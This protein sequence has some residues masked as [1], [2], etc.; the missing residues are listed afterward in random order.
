[1]KILYLTGIT[2]QP[3]SKGQSKI[4]RANGK[5]SEKENDTMP[6]SWFI[7]NGLRPPPDAEDDEIERDDYG[8]VLLDPEDVDEVGIP[9]SL[10]LKYY[11]G[12]EGCT[13][14]TSIVY[15]TFAY[16]FSVFEDIE[17]INDYVNYLSSPWHVRKWAEIKIDW[18]N[19][20]RKIGLTK[21]KNNNINN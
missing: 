18:L 17:E 1:M 9:I 16:Q 8:S 4:D 5:K 13:D 20:K 14:G 21:I 15:S 2:T 19:F 12:A 3:N 7:E 6:K 10:P 11:A